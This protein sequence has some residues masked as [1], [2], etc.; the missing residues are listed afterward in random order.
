MWPSLVTKECDTK[1]LTENTGQ[2]FKDLD[3]LRALALTLQDPEASELASL[4]LPGEAALPF[5]RHCHPLSWMNRCAKR[6]HVS[7]TVHKLSHSLQILTRRRC[8][9]CYKMSKRKAH[10]T[11]PFKSRGRYQSTV[12]RNTSWWL[13]VP[14][15]LCST[16]P[17]DTV[18]EGSYSKPFMFWAQ[19]PH[20]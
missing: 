3:Y 20:L 14:V 17:C 16:F 4:P 18:C 15:C 19:F 10:W 8:S 6:R 5:Q 11:V 2:N 13:V 7:I 1:S 12:F 9:I